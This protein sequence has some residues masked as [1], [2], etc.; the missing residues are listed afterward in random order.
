[1]AAQG[2]QRGAIPPFAPVGSRL[3]WG[4]AG[5]KRS[6]LGLTF[7]DPA[8]RPAPASPLGGPPPLPLPPTRGRPRPPPGSQPGAA[9]PTAAWGGSGRPLERSGQ[10]RA[11]RAA[12]PEARVRGRWGARWRGRGGGRCWREEI[13]WD[14]GEGLSSGRPPTTTPNYPHCGS[15]LHLLPTPPYQGSPA[16]P[17]AC[18]SPHPSNGSQSNWDNSNWPLHTGARRSP[19][20]RSGSRASAVP[21][22][23]CSAGRR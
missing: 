12:G 19:G 11:V 9:A 14:Q 2:V 21:P 8:S 1:M 4:G 16:L 7:G 3:P 18:W 23:R 22:P 13:A 10:G 15:D 5:Q 17:G 6:P 20:S